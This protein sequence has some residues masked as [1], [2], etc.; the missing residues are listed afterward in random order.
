MKSKPAG[1]IENHLADLRER[2]G[3]SASRLA[4]MVGVSRQTIYAMQ[5]GEYVPNTL[6]A[7][8]LAHA[9]EAEVEDLF[10]LR[11]ELR[12]PKLHDE[13][14]ALLP[15]SELPQPGQTVQLCRV[16]RQLIASVP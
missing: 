2:R 16:D 10:G 11:G 15:G 1:D 12:A 6:V 8:R 13:K 9:L 3:L 4:Q 7:L 14:A 5:A